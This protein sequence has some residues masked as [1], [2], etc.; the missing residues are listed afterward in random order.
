[1]NILIING[2]Q[3]KG[4]TYHI[5]HQ[6]VSKLDPRLQPVIT[7]FFL[8]K[9]MP[10]FC[11]GCYNC[12]YKGEERCPHANQ[13]D[14]IRKAMSASDLII[15]T[16]PVYVFDVSG[17]LKA[18]FDHFGY[19]WMSHRPRSEMFKT[20]GLS[21]VT[22]A[23]AGMKP[24]SKTIQTNMKWWG[25]RKTFSF[26]EAVMASSYADISPERLKKIDEKTTVLARRLSL[27]LMKTKLPAPS[28]KTQFL[29]KI[30]TLGKKG[31]PE[32]NALD[33]AYWKNKGFLD[34]EKPWKQSSLT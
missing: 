16:S 21:V 15:V 33:T 7:E 28:L 3:R 5:T 25:M 12:I 23:G 14:P 24:T 34:G 27:E 20:I 29:F 18:L 6:I 30:M 4:S 11:V 31:H 1:M 2:T 22:G 13:V 8:P 32:W 17:Q 26:S 19:Q 9:D 10:H